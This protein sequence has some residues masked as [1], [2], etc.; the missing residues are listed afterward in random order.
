MPRSLSLLAVLLP[1]LAVSQFDGPIG[2][3]NH[4]AVALPFLRFEPARSP[5]QPGERGWEFGWTAANEF[6][7]EGPR[8]EDAETSRLLIRYRQ[9]LPK[10]QEFW[11]DVPI[12]DRS[13][14]FLDPIID[15]WHK[16]V[17]GWSDP[18]R[19]ATP[20]G[21][22][23]ISLAGTYSF[24]SA[25]GVGDVSVGLAKSITSR[26]V[27]RAAVKLPTGN[28]AQLIGSGGLDFGLSL[29]HRI[30][31][32]SKFELHGQLAVIAQGKDPSLPHV[33][34]LVFQGMLALVYKRNSRDTFALQW[35]HEDSPT[36]DGVSQDAHRTLS[37][38]YRRRLSSKD[39]VEFI[40]ME[41]RDIWRKRLELANEAPDFTV[42]V[43]YLVKF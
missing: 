8:Y 5:L 14:G 36:V 21:G 40:V 19:N 20:F 29:D 22:S 42:G 32:G 34:S 13:G 12:V 15:G 28:A 23:V 41:D 11:V 17:L 39:A 18:V 10:R 9:G 37:V 27:L 33:R 26:T 38:G 25:F 16:G 2:A 35:Q 24:G 30:A 4:R 6:R 31:L 1:S 43:R 7:S 3:R